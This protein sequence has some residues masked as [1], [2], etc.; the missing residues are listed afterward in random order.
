[1][2]EGTSLA[3]A[4]RVLTLGRDY[5]YFAKVDC[6]QQSLITTMV[7][8]AT[9]ITPNLLALVP[10]DEPEVLGFVK[11]VL[12]DPDVDRERLENVLA[13]TLGRAPTRLVF[14]FSE[15]EVFRVTAGFF[16]E[17]VL[18]MPGESLRRLAIRDKGGKAAAKA[19]FDTRTR[20]RAAS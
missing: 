7:P 15:L 17:I 6:T 2:V 9:V 4:V 1:M 11:A 12:A 14:R 3:R 19:F 5:L 16:G 20:E 10:L 18:K 8:R 13:S